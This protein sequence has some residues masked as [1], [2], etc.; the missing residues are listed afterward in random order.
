M[1]LLAHSLVMCVLFAASNDVDFSFSIFFSF[2][3][4][5]NMLGHSIKANCFEGGM[6]AVHQHH[7]ITASST[8]I[9]PS[10]PHQSSVERN[11]ITVSSLNHKTQDIL[12][13][14]Y[15]YL[16]NAKWIFVVICAL[17]CFSDLSV[18]WSCWFV[19]NRPQNDNYVIM[20]VV[21]YFILCKFR[22]NC[23]FTF[24]FLR[25]KE[26]YLAICY[27]CGTLS[28]VSSPIAFCNHVVYV[29][30]LYHI[31]SEANRIHSNIL[32]IKVNLTK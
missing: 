32:P 11:L 15:N 4:P 19:A 14:D 23:G 8:S 29:S 22:V 18:F 20:I 5:T 16:S 24:Q 31:R 10:M 28:G 3:A 2:S 25:C 12:Q 6:Y 7:L 26:D 27:E 9:H 13:D 21:R 30:L 1:L 17:L